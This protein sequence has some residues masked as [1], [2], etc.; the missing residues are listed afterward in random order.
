M[1]AKVI[2][3]DES[4]EFIGFELTSDSGRVQLLNI[5][6]PQSD[7]EN[8]L[9]YFNKMVKSINDANGQRLNLSRVASDLSKVTKK[10]AETSA[11]NISRKELNWQ[12]DSL[13]KKL[14]NEGRITKSE[15]SEFIIKRKK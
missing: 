4:N 5:Q 11:I 14:L 9:K 3:V 6:Y 8:V 7:K 2:K 15:V 1:K 13:V 12:Y 10:F